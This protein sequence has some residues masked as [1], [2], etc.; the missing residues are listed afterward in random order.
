MHDE[1]IWKAPRRVKVTYNK[2]WHGKRTSFKSLYDCEQ[3]LKSLFSDDTH[4]V[5]PDEDVEDAASAEV[6][7]MCCGNHKRC[8]VVLLV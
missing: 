3:Y 6:L 4:I 7:T 2:G 1:K 5:L 8:A